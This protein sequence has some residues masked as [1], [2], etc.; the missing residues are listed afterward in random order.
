MLHELMDLLKL[1]MDLK[2]SDLHL[3]PGLS[4]IMRVD[5]ELMMMKEFPIL[6][7]HII[8][9][10]INEMLN[11]KQQK[12]LE[13]IKEL[14]FSYTISGV[15]N[16]RVNIFYQLHGISCVFRIIPLYIPT[17]EMINAP[18]ILKQLLQ[19]SNG[20]ILIS[21]LTG[22]GK[23]TTLAAMMEEINIHQACHIITIE[24]PIEYIYQSKKS[25]VHQRQ[26]SRDTHS[27]S[28]AL[29]AALRED[30]DIILVGEM[31]D[32]ETMRLTLTA[33]E[34]GHLV[35]ATLHTSSAS[36][37]INRI[38]DVFPT[39]EK[40]LVRNLLSESLQAVICQTLVKYKTSGRIAA[41]EIMLGTPA[42]R[43]LIR[44]DKI[45][46]TYS[47]MQ[48]GN[49]AGMCTMAQALNKLQMII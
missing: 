30:P 45:A 16:F 37:A 11:D 6:N 2:A 36:H 40:N 43:N 44:E 1:G 5:G 27:F 29:R 46:Q 35:L 17:L 18:P 34:T 41:Y 48:T 9:K 31:R 22:C 33:A 21:G 20:L 49:Q 14:D 24:D 23:S 38:I 10:F 15:A 47:V 26:I 32:L 13:V 19:L 4:P 42:I 7:N 8:R 25:L 12:E 39:G 28:T 3:S